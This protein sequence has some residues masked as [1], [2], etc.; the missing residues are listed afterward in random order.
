MTKHSFGQTAINL[1]LKKKCATSNITHVFFHPGSA[2]AD[3]RA[4]ASSSA[5]LMSHLTAKAHLSAIVPQHLPLHYTPITACPTP[6]HPPKHYLHWAWHRALQLIQQALHTGTHIFNPTPTIPLW[7]FFCRGCSLPSCRA[8]ALW[9][10]IVRS[11]HIGQWWASAD[12]IFRRE[13]QSC[14][15]TQ[16]HIYMQIREK[17]N[18]LPRNPVES[19]SSRIFRT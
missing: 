1:S 13:E 2:A 7:F 3:R 4:W 11:G 15:D 14:S 10:D 19:P 12:F 8:A 17:N 18:M 16:V 6:L 5:Y 9:D